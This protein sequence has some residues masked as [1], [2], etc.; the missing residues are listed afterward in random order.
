MKATINIL[1][2]LF[3]ARFYAINTGFFLFLFLL[4]FGV[5]Q[6]GALISYHLS[7][8]EFILSSPTSTIIAFAIWL[9]YNY[10]CLAFIHSIIRNP[11][12]HFLNCLQCHRKRTLVF[13]IAATHLLLYLPVLLYSA[14]VFVLGV[15]KQL[16]WASFFVACF[17]FGVIVFSTFS[18][19][20]AFLYPWQRLFPWRISMS[21][22]PRKTFF[23]LL[24]WFTY[25]E[26]KRTLLLLKIVSVLLLFIPLELN[27]D[28]F[29]FSDF[30]LVFQICIASHAMIAYY[31]VQFIETKMRWL[32]N[33]PRSPIQF[34]ALYASTFFVILIPE[35]VY[36]LKHASLLSQTTNALSLIL[37]F[38][39]QLLLYT[40]LQYQRGMNMPEYT[41]QVFVICLASAFTMPL[42]QFALI[43]TVEFV[44]ALSL[45]W[46]L[47]PM[48]EK[49]NNL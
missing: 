28:N 33:M 18:I 11:A 9:A 5:V 29:Q 23:S 45:F 24:L 3:V 44:I 32:R 40:A 31:Y 46:E 36:L 34:F 43:G 6:G 49:N 15:H 26:R 13:L 47:Y 21:W 16:Y 30:A 20:Q 2:K 10:K 22:K 25:H 17:Q 1:S 4:L 27:K 7:L 12:N 14:C 39:S 41:L 38:I 8:M 19:Y 48:Y 37:F 42:K 35:M